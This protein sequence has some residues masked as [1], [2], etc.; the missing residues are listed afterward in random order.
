MLGVGGGGT[1]DQG[2]GEARGRADELPRV[3]S[4]GPPELGFFFGRIVIVQLKSFLCCSRFI[5]CSSCVNNAV[6]K[7]WLVLFH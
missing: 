2:G 6:Q 7:K 5:H 1:Y 3:S 4:S